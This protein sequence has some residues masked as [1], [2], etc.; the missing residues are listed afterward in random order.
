[1]TGSK[2]AGMGAVA[3]IVGVAAMTLAEKLEQQ[4]T[5][6]PNSYVPAETLARLTH[7]AP[8]DG[9]HRLVLNWAMQWG[10]GA[11]FGGLRGWMASRGLRGPM[12][13]FMFMNARLLGDQTLENVTKAGAPPWT[14]P[15][16]EQVID[17]AHKAV[18]AFA[19][20]YAA[21]RLIPGPRGIPAPVR[22]WSE[23][24]ASHPDGRHHR[25]V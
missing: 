4:F 19:T 21:D 10:Q 20:G 22:P 16:D 13:S 5:G 1:M 23:R 6:R 17:L 9:R 25:G 8:R 15:V 3:G 12:G 2:A 11:L 18:Y 14:W 24:D 7:T